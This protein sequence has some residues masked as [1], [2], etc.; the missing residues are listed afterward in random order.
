MSEDFNFND[1]FFADVEKRGVIRLPKT[2][3]ARINDQT[4][5]VLNISNKG[6]LLETDMPVYL[7]PISKIINFD[8]EINGQWMSIDGTIK[9]VATDQLYSRVGIFIKWAP[10]LYVDYLKKL[11]S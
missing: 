7:F 1:L 2:L 6:V 4:C 9:W 3:S 8:L 5:A 11:Y 10:D